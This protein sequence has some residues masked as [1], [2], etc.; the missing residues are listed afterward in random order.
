MYAMEAGNAH[1]TTWN[2]Y[3]VGVN[4]NN[5][6]QFKIIENRGVFYLAEKA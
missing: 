1:W 5:L 3:I 4:M 6:P 2:D